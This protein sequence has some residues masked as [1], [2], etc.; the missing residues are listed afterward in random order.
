M[1]HLLKNGR[2]KENKYHKQR[3]Y[4]LRNNN[5]DQTKNVMEQSSSSEDNSS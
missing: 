2:I 1:P 3:N 5:M 4:I